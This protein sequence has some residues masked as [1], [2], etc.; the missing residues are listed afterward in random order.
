MTSHPH[1]HTYTH[2]YT[3]TWQT[4][5]QYKKKS[6]FKSNKK[7][8]YFLQLI[9]LISDQLISEGKWKKLCVFFWNVSIQIWFKWEYFRTEITLICWRV[10]NLVVSFLILKGKFFLALIAKKVIFVIFV[11]FALSFMFIQTLVGI[12]ALVTTIAFESFCFQMFWVHVT[13]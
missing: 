8:I 5:F 12:K 11:T 10:V 7:Y 13:F 3:Y 2:V 4:I 9:N 1:T 6:L